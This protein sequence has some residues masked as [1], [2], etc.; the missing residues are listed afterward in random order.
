M[1]PNETLRALRGAVRHMNDVGH[2]LDERENQC[3]RTVVELFEALDTWLS[4]GGFP[5]EEWREG[6]DAPASGMH[7]L[8]GDA[9]KWYVFD[10]DR[11]IAGPFAR[12]VEGN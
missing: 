4:K 9:G 3:V 2:E 1:D 6:P 8:E 5:P 12:P 7:V 11:P 10:G